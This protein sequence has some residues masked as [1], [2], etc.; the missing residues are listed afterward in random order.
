MPDHA[1]Y[2]EFNRIS[3]VIQQALS[4][5]QTATLVRVDACTNDGGLSPVGLVD[6]TPLVNQVDGG[7]NA[8]PHVTIFNIPYCRVQG[9]SNA[10]IIDPEVGDIGICVFASRDISK[11]KS[12]RSQ[13]NP[14]SNRRY[15]FSD[16]MY[17]GGILNGVPSQ[18]IKFNISGIEI[19]SPNSVTINSSS[20]MKII[21]PTLEITGDV[22]VSGKIT[23]S[24][25]VV[26]SGISSSG[27]TH[28]GVQP[29]PG[30]TGAPS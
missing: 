23:S 11:I 10:I 19:I 24:G 6:I 13:G 8:T 1:S 28:G 3:F 2:G 5:I 27:H 21:S 18:Y 9:G 14:G 12:T 4:K 17:I 7:N 22:V 26:A 20:P 15:S 30:S 16:G 25:D 29:G